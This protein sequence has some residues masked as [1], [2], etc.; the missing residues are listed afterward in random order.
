[1]SCYGFFVSASSIWCVGV[2]RVLDDEL[3]ES[4]ECEVWIRTY[5]YISHILY[6]YRHDYNQA[7]WNV[8]VKHVITQSAFQH[9]NDLQTCEIAF[10]CRVN[11]NKKKKN[12]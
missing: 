5:L 7:S 8:G 1:M 12:V 10:G 11:K 3:V 9:E 4:L 6:T 2:K